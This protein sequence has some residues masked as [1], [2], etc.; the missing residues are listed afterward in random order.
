MYM[1]IARDNLEKFC[2]SNSTVKMITQATNA[3]TLYEN[4]NNAFVIVIRHLL[5]Q[6]SNVNA[7]ILHLIFHSSDF[8]N[9]IE[10]S[11]INGL[12]LNTFIKT[13]IIKRLVKVKP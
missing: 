10:F 8:L 6:I 9:I 4:V 13:F 7:T 1:I 2:N 3:K 5:G 11:I 12:Q